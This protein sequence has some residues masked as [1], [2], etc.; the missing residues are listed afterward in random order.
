M[1][2]E[3]LTHGGADAQGDA[4]ESEARVLGHE[5]EGGGE[6]TLLQERHAGQEAGEQVNPRHHLDGAHLVLSVEGA[7]PVRGKRVKAHVAHED[8]ETGKCCA[9]VR[10]TVSRLA[11]QEGNHAHRDKDSHH[12][13]VILVLLVTHNLSHQHHWD[14]FAGLGQDLGGEADVLE[15]FVLTPAR[16]DVGEGA[17]AVLVERGL[18]SGLSLQFH[19]NQGNEEGEDSVDKDK[20]LRVLVHPLVTLT[21][22]IAGRHDL[23]LKVSPG[24]IGPNETNTTEED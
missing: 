19:Y 12:V 2:Y 8:D 20:E 5:R 11:E 24:C 9:L 6:H 13:L 21:V 22:L 10:M 14:D 7:L 4:V 17:V 1:E 16:H 18:V 3:E 23:L 15:G